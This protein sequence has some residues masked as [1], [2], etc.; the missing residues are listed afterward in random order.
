[1]I[2]GK[3]REPMGKFYDQKLRV[4]MRV[5]N[6]LLDSLRR[7]KMLA[8]RYEDLITVE[9]FLHLRAF[10]NLNFS[11]QLRDNIRDLMFTFLDVLTFEVI[12][13][14]DREMTSMSPLTASYNYSTPDFAKFLWSFK[15]VPLPSN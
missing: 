15:D 13:H 9:L 2:V 5:Y 3:F 6:S 11:F 12:K 7:K 8:E 14:I 4:I 10:T 1:M